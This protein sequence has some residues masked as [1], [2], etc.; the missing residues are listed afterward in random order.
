[1]YLPEAIL[2]SVQV[3]RS[4]S[5]STS[6][7]VMIMKATNYKCKILAFAAQKLPLK[8]ILPQQNQNILAKNSFPLSGY[9]VS[10]LFMI[11]IANL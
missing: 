10:G 2:H 4:Y 6:V 1:M 7:H 5:I 8:S 3:F 11:Y 9:V